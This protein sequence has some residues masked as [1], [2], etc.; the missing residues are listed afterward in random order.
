MSMSLSSLRIASAP[1]SASK[2]VA[3]LLARLAVL[4]LGEQLLVLQ[5]RL[6]GIGDDVGLEVEDLLELFQ[7]HV[8]EGADPARQALQKPD[9]G[10]RRG[11]L[12]VAHAL[13]AHFGL[14]HL[15][16][17]LFAD[18]AAVPHALVFAAVALVVLGRAEDL[19]A[20]Q[21][22]PLRLEGAVVD[23][24]RLLD[25]AVRPGA[26]LLR[27]GERDPQRVEVERVLRFL[28]Q[29]EEIF[30]WFSLESRGGSASDCFALSFLRAA[31]RPSAR[32]CSSFTMTLKDSGRPGS[33]TFSP[34]TMASYMRVRPATSS[35]LTVSISWRL[36]AAP[37]ASSAQTSI[38]PRRWP[39]NWALPPSGCWVTSEYGPVERAWILSSTR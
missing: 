23:G 21:A 9:V 39:P 11:E 18:D 25:F 10:H 33:S 24:L 13:A 22:V 28:E 8:E 7:R 34:L 4:L 29:I 37:Y 30:H 6:A 26:D 3:E 32:L 15:D 27:R 19:G 38:S 17:A 2:A 1:I 35:D 36:Y 31:R 12:D 20:E 14:D 5:R 16:A